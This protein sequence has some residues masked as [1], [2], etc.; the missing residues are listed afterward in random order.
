M[1]KKKRKTET[2]KRSL[3]L[4]T[5]SIVG[6]IAVMAFCLR[7][8]LC[9]G[10]IFTSEGVKF[11][12]TDCYY[13]MR[14]VDNMVHNFPHLMSLDHYLL[15][16]DGQNIWS[17][18]LFARLLAG[19]SWLFGL[20]SP[21]QQTIDTVCAFMPAVMGTL[22]V[23]PVYFI[24]K[25]L[26]GRWAGI[27]A[28][29]LVAVMPG[30]FM[31]RSALGSADHHVAEVLFT[32][33]AVMF[34]VMAIKVASQRGIGFGSLGKREAVKPIIYSILGG[35]F[36]G[37]YALTWQ[38]GSLLLLIVSLYLAVQFAIDHLRHR[39]SSYLCV[40]GAVFILVGMAVF[41]PTA[42]VLVSRSFYVVSVAVAL[43]M[44]F[45]L[46]GL[47]RFMGKMGIRV[48]YYP[49]VLLGLGAIGLAIFRVMMPSLFGE[50]AGALVYIFKPTATHLTTIEMQPLLFPSGSFDLS[51]VWGNFGLAVFVAI[52]VLGVMVYGMVRK[53][54]ADKSLMVIWTVVVLFIAIAQRRFAYYLA[55]NVALLSGYASWLVLKWA[56]LRESSGELGKGRRERV[57]AAGIVSVFVVVVVVFVVLFIP[58]LPSAIAVASSAP[59][60]PSDAWCES[61]EWLRKNSPEPFNSGSDAYDQLNVAGNAS[62]GVLSWWDYGW[63]IVRTAHRVPDVNPGQVPELQ[64]EVATF[65]TAKDEPSADD[66][67]DKLG[68]EY[69]VIDIDS[70]LGKFWAIATYAGKSPSEYFGVYY[71]QDGQQLQPVQLFYPEYY[72]SLAVRLYNFGGKA[73]SPSRIVAIS[74]EERQDAKG[75]IFKLITDAQQFSDYDNAVAFANQKSGNCRI[76]SDSPFASPVP[77]EDTKGYG[78]VY[79]SSSKYELF[80]T[81]VSGVK[82]FRRCE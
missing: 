19:A 8:C 73:M 37:I 5:A 42:M 40:V 75:N 29:A 38:G 45:V 74:Y 78:E 44:P 41:L 22:V 62:Y 20:G 23:I 71:V 60:V 47:S 18:A 46:L 1:S 63:W 59:Y 25:T 9:Y 14:L 65:L 39:D 69:V 68:A 32:A 81:E 80:G 67:A 48:L 3:W 17:Y 28:S 24:G 58:I 53:G 6:L 50:L 79:Q 49:I 82:I 7:V 13:Y 66:I 77:L 15:Y 43:T 57:S 54:E 16:P 4:V 55:V 61:L 56:G 76:V 70:V 33:T 72:Q 51:I 34:L 36:F 52:A 21:T 27:C 11:N 10:L 35:L 31:G 30:E 12:G 64:A 26:W 2:K